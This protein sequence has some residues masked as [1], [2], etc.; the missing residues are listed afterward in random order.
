M[1]ADGLLPPTKLPKP[2]KSC[3]VGDGVRAV[4]SSVEAIE[5]SIFLDRVESPIGGC[6]QIYDTWQSEMLDSTLTSEHVVILHI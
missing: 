3:I 6:V 4:N 2:P 1:P 5:D